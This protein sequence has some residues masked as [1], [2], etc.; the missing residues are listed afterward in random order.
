M[1]TFP[2]FTYLSLLCSILAPYLSWLGYSPV[3]QLLISICAFTMWLDM[4][5]FSRSMQVSVALL[6]GISAYIVYSYPFTTI[7]WSGI[8]YTATIFSYTSRVLLYKQIGYSRLLWMEPVV[9]SCSV[10]LYTYELAG[11]PLKIVSIVAGI[12]MVLLTFTSFVGYKDRHQ[13]AALLRN[14]FLNP[15]AKAPGFSLPGHDD[16]MFNL[17]DHL[18]KRDMLLIFVRGDWCPSCHIMLRTYERNRLKFQSK[19]I[20]LVAIGPDPVG[21]NKEMV[22]KL[23]LEYFLLSDVKQEVSMKYFLKI[24]PNHV[25]ANYE[26][27]IPLPASFLVDKKGIIRY[28]SRAD[29]AGESLQPE[30][31]FDV[32]D[33]LK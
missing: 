25:A 22:K 27:G 13:L 1:R 2:L 21:V 5:K 9:I 7:S 31:I 16:V 14:S 23:D 17:S 11:Q 33:K 10:F 3:A 28:T 8:A 29:R 15:G 24:Q 20:L 30:L 4:N 6:T 12:P 32:L 18:G 19:N 26:E